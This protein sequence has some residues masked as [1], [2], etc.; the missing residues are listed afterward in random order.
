MARQVFVGGPVDSVKAKA[1]TFV[2]VVLG[3]QTGKELFKR[4]LRA[5]AAK[6]PKELREKVSKASV[7]E[8]REFI[9]YNKGRILEE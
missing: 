8:I 1:K 6:M 3:D 9:P 7:E 4:I 5:L 2:I